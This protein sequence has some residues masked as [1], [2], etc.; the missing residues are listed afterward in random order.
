M[1][2]SAGKDSNRPG[3]NGGRSPRLGPAVVAACAV[4]LVCGCSLNYEEAALEEQTSASIP[5][6][7]ASNVIHRVNRDGRLSMQMEAARAETYNSTNTTVLTDAHFVEY[8]DKGKKAT[9]GSAHRVVFHSDT[10]NAEISGSVRVHSASEKGS[11]AAE[12]LSWVKKIRKLSAAPD[13]MVLI[14]KDDGTYISGTGFTGDF[15][16]RQVTFSGPVRGRYV[17]EEKK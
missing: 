13:E 5:D 6:T 10:E 4:L 8:D 16:A 11:V 12:S 2:G 14:Q 9:E 1:P 17:W 3:L 15:Q 7:V